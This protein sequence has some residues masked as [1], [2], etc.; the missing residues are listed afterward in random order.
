M[1]GAAP[2]AGC[3]EL[4]CRRRWVPVSRAHAPVAPATADPAAGLSLKAAVACLCWYPQTNCKHNTAAGLASCLACLLSVHSMAQVSN[5]A[6][7]AMPRLVLHTVLHVCSLLHCCLQG[8]HQQRPQGH[9]Q[10]MERNHLRLQ[11]VAGPGLHRLMVQHILRRGL[12]H[13][14]RRQQHVSTVLGAG[15]AGK[16][17]R[18]WKALICQPLEAPNPACT[19]AI[20]PACLN[21]QCD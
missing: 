10:L 7:P 3:L 17:D 5:Q 19:P 8:R 20:L 16:A 21:P 14:R 4:C 18:P 12:Q 13:F 2:I 9:L 11:P 15:T 1:G 6:S